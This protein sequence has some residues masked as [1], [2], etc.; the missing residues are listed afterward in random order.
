MSDAVE[1]DY[2]VSFATSGWH[3][4]PFDLMFALDPH[5][6]EG[7]GAVALQFYK[8]RRGFSDLGKGT[9]RVFERQTDQLHSLL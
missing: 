5:C 2:S 7:H 3:T 1:D 6:F 8:G 9:P 4:N